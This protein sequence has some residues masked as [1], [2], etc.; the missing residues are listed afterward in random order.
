MPGGERV[1]GIH[2]PS[3]GPAGPVGC[4]GATIVLVVVWVL[5]GAAALVIWSLLRDVG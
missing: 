2:V 1:L 4:L 3:T 5:L